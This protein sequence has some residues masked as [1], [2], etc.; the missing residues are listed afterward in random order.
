VIGAQEAAERL[1]ERV[2]CSDG[3]DA[4]RLALTARLDIEMAVTVGD[5]SGDL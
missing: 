1:C 4:A 5:R 2:I 3:A